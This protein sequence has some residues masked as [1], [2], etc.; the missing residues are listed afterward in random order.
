[1]GNLQVCLAVFSIAVAVGAAGVAF[2][3]PES[4][5]EF[6]ASSVVALLELVIEADAD[7]ARR[8]LAILAEKSQSGEISAAQI[9]SLRSRLDGTLQRILKSKQHALYADAAILA[10]AW[11]DPAGKRVARAIVHDAERSDD[12]RLA[13]FESLVASGGADLPSMAAK[14]LAGDKANSISFRGKLL[15]AL[16]RLEKPEVGSIVLETFPNLEDELKPQAIELLTQRAVWA[17]KLL[18]KIRSKQLSPDVL[19]VNQVKKLLATDDPKVK[20]HV[21]ATWGAVRTERDE[22]REAVVKQIRTLLS[23][24]PG[25]PYKGQMVFAKVCGQC[26]RIYGQ[27]QDVGPDITGNGRASFDQLLSNVFDPSLVIGQAYQARTVVTL[28]G[29]VLTGLPVEDS[30]QRI[31]LKGQGGKTETIAREDID[32][33]QTSKLSLMPEGLERQL[34]PQEIADLFAFLTLDGPPS[35][36]KARYIP[37]TPTPARQQR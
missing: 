15:S 19:N 8:C 7:S 6:D 3:A 1:M 11:N 2:A 32:E 27:G 4:E 26:H 21:T 13:A 5:Q 37:G 20:R 18:S 33:V 9:K 25:D 14:L 10:A 35:D 28:D 30:E 36:P 23:Q 16:G 17:K 29:R 31:V 12:Q 34:K 24:I 22:Q